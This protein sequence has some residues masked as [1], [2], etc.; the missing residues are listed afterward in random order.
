MRTIRFSRAEL[1]VKYDRPFLAQDSQ[2]LQVVVREAGTAVQRD[3]WRRF[4]RTDDFV[5]DS[6]AGDVD[7]AFFHRA[8]EREL[9]IIR[10]SR[11]CDGQT[12]NEHQQNQLWY[13]ARAPNRHRELPP[14]SAYSLAR[15]KRNA[16]MAWHRPAASSTTHAQWPLRMSP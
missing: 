10:R 9:R 6:A 8:S 13:R 1:I 11:A 16:A 14:A 2:W 12:E 4:S 5:P 7:V 3:Q 15:E